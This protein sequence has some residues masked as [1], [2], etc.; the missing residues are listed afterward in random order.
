[1]NPLSSHPL[2]VNNFLKLFISD[3]APDKSP[4]ITFIIPLLHIAQPLFGNV[5]RVVIALSY[6]PRGIDNVPFDIAAAFLAFERSN[7]SAFRTCS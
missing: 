4:D 2:S 5:V 7:F 3:L 6:S 1:M